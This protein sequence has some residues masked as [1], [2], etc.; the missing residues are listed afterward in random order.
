MERLIGLVLT[1][2]C[3]FRTEAVEYHKYGIRAACNETSSEL[4]LFFDEET[5]VYFDAEENIF[6]ST[7]PDFAYPVILPHVTTEALKAEMFCKT[8]IAVLNE[9]YMNPPEELVPPWSS[10]YP[11][12]E[13]V[14]N[15]KNTLI[16]HVT[17]FFPPPVRVLWS[18][19]DISVTEG[20]YLS[21]HYSNSDGTL[22]VFS[23]LSFSPEEGDIYSC[24]VDHQALKT[25]QTRIW[26]VELEQPNILPSVLC[27][28]GLVLGLLGVTIAAFFITK[29]NGYHH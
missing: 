25:P 8:V 15:V 16:C 11:R 22:T 24:T 1:T 4:S 20:V 13:V 21:Q 27:G 7:I 10:I 12:S 6:I 3:V 18:R 9:A 26:E 29:A 2:I 28:V 23:T 5:I 14:V 19:N 17:G